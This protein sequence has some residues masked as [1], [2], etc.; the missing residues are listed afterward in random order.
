MRKDKIQD[1]TKY[2]IVE[3]TKIGLVAIYATSYVANDTKK[4][5]VYVETIMINKSSG[6]FRQTMVTAE[7]NKKADMNYR[8]TCQAGK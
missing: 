1:N 2:R 4:P 3:D 7:D 5:E 8:G 6:E